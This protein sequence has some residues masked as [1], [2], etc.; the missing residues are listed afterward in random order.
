MLCDVG[1]YNMGG[2]ISAKAPSILHFKDKYTDVTSYSTIVTTT[3]TKN[4]LL[5]LAVAL[6]TKIKQTNKIHH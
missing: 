1:N 4:L 6:K 3:A 5:G 2:M